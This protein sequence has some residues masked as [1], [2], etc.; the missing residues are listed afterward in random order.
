MHHHQ[1]HSKVRLI[2]IQMK[3]NLNF[4]L[5][6]LKEE[7]YMCIML[8]NQLFIFVLSGVFAAKVEATVLFEAPRPFAKKDHN[9]MKK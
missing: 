6:F 3:K 5:N 9:K 4:F 7:T 1:I 2:Y 8:K